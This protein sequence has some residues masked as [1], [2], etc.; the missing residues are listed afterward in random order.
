M[1]QSYR[2]KGG[3]TDKLRGVPVGVVFLTF[4]LEHAQGPTVYNTLQERGE[5][6]LMSPLN[7]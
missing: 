2:I 3:A 4:S 7:L 5:K 6:A 1:S